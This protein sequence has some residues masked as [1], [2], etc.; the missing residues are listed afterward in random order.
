MSNSQVFDIVDKNN[1]LEQQQDMQD[2]QHDLQDLQDLQQAQHPQLQ[3][4]DEQSVQLTNYSVPSSP[5]PSSL[6]TNP[7]KW[8]TVFLL[9]ADGFWSSL[10]GPIL[11]PCMKYLEKYL[12]KTETEI[13]ISV[14]LYF[15][16]QGLSPSIFA[17]LSDVYGRRPVIVQALLL[18]TVFSVGIANLKNYATLMVLRFFQGCAISSCIPINSGVASDISDKATRGLFTGATAGLTLIGQALGPLIACLIINDDFQNA[19]EPWRAV[20][21]F[22]TIGA[23]ITFLTHSFFLVE[24][25]KKIVGNLSIK[26]KKWYNR[27]P[28]LMFMK[29]QLKF[30]NPDT[31]TLVVPPKNGKGAKIDFT[32]PFKICCHPEVFLTLLPGGL[33]FALWTI[34]LNTIASSLSEAPYNYSIKKI[35]LIYLAPGLSGILGSIITGRFID[36][37]YK[38]SIRSFNMKKEKGLLPPNADF[39]L[40]RARVIISMPQNFLSVVAYILFGWSVTKHWPVPVTVVMSS[41]GSYASMATLATSSALLVDLYPTQA[42]SATASYNMIRCLLAAL[43]TGVLDLMNKKIT[44]GGTFTLLSALVLVGNFV[45]FIP[46][47][48][49][50]QWKKDRLLK[51]LKRDEANLRKEEM[52]PTPTYCSEKDVRSLHED[53]PSSETEICSEEDEYIKR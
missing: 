20:F 27:A 7:Q 8:A 28:V 40:I 50:M 45:M 32:S 19:A 39:N 18:Y 4:D 12:H 36:F 37:M 30:D 6:L 35:G 48:Y 17:N 29:K 51:N 47:K 46:M 41:L 13:N 34:N 22:L 5:P 42:S 3:N 21:Y 49:G 23:G 9:V 33:Q 1:T 25:N 24:T 31:E 11:F 38:K 52:T 15:I 53:T 10:G 43:F 26:P 2:L 14:L 44:I 16:A